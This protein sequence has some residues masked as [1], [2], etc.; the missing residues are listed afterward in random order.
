MEKW[1]RNPAPGE[2]C[3]TEILCH[4]RDVEREVNLPRFRKMLAEQNPFLAGEATDTWVK[5]RKNAEQDGRQA[6]IEFTAARKEVLAL[7]EGLVEEWS[8]PARHAIFG[9]TTLQE[10]VGFVAAHD[11]AHVQQVWK[12]LPR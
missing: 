8:W 3:L 11:R 4:L 10:L 5:E 7:L 12:T 1:T 9:P 6:L 2:W